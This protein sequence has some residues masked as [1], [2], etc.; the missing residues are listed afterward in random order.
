MFY[1]TYMVRLAGSEKFYVGRHS[2]WRHPADDP[3]TG[4]GK[5]VNQIKDKSLLIREEL[6][7]FDSEAALREAE[8]ALIAVHIDDKNC[9]NFNE[10]PVGFSSRFN[11]N[12]TTA[13]RARL[14]KKAI[15]EN[16]MRGKSHTEESR[17]KISKAVSGKNNPFYGKHHTQSTKDKL[18]SL[19]TGSLWSDEQK[20]NLSESRKLEYMNGFRTP[21]RYWQDRSLPETT[22]EKIRAAALRRPDAVCPHCLGSFK[23]H[24]LKRW[25]GDSCRN[26]S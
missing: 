3:Y 18:S 21:N 7:F 8:Q 10:N 4:S 17:K 9:M 16:P 11:P 19:R 12:K 6:Q 15:E 25:H 13:A 23:P 2:S 20:R 14:R 5:W 24:T 22:K 26:K 1:Y